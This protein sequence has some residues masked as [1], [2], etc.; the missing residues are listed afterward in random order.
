[1]SMTFLSIL[2]IPSVSATTVRIDSLIDT[3]GPV[4]EKQ[5]VHSNSLESG[6][7]YRSSLMSNG[8]SLQEAK[9]T[10]YEK[11]E[12]DTTTI[13]T[14]DSQGRGHMVASELIGY[15]FLSFAANGT[16]TEPSC[17][18]SQPY[19]VSADTTNVPI[20][21]AR[22]LAG[23]SVATGDTL[24]YQS[25]GHV[26]PEDLSYQISVAPRE[27]ENTTDARVSTMAAYLVDSK[28]GGTRVH[29]DLV[30]AGQLGQLRQSYQMGTRYQTDQQ[31]SV[32]GA[33]IEKVTVYDVSVSES[34]TT[35]A[36]NKLTYA[37]GATVGQ[38]AFHEIRLL[39]LD[40]GI[41]TTRL[42]TYDRKETSGGIIVTEQ[43]RAERDALSGSGSGTDPVCIFSLIQ[44]QDEA[45]ALESAGA[46]A[47]SRIIGA[48]NISSE[49]ITR[50]SFD[51]GGAG[52]D[53]QYETHILAPVDLR[54]EF[55]LYVHDLDG[56]GLYEDVNGNG[57]LDF[58]DLIVLFDNMAWL[59]EDERGLLFDY[60]RNG[61]LDYAD[62]LVLFDMIQKG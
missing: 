28:T 41:D 54:S 11:G 6:V 42:I 26:R 20:S 1:M 40:G 32:E 35:S 9:N 29:E 19:A 55:E 53:L 21:Y 52:I 2:S 62:L 36:V 34:A 23:S 17:V 51:S 3:V 10:L 14:Y 16:G 43:V 18:F 25:V 24:A 12:L 50:V 33:V 30:I 56:D 31:L 38:G 15:Q 57:R 7:L 8:G 60:N 5:V 22:G 37:A 39:N 48:D 4:V 46:Y 61:K 59:V 44:K 58:A 49:T 45:G 47:S 13:V 27:G